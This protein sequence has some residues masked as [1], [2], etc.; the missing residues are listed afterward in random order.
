[1]IIAVAALG[2]L[3]HAT[4]QPAQA[5]R[6]AFKDDLGSRRLGHRL[7][8]PRGDDATATLIAQTGRSTAPPSSGQEADGFLDSLRVIDRADRL[9]YADSLVG[10]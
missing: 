4:E 5:V 1:M 3:A 9:G 2:R 10:D 6:R 8:Y 7:Q